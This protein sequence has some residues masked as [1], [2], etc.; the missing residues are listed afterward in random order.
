[1]IGSGRFS[2]LKSKTLFSNL[3][4]RDSLHYFGEVI[5][6]F[7]LKLETMPDFKDFKV[8]NQNPN[9]PLSTSPIK[10]GYCY[11]NGTIETTLLNVSN[12]PSH[13]APFLI[14]GLYFNSEMSDLVGI[15]VSR[16][17]EGNTYIR[18][19]QLEFRQVF[20]IALS[21]QPGGDE[22]CK[23]FYKIIENENIPNIES[24]QEGRKIWTKSNLAVHLK[25][26]IQ[27]LEAIS[28][29]QEVNKPNDILRDTNTSL[30]QKG[31]FMEFLEE[32]DP[33]TGDH[34]DT[35]HG[36]FVL[37]FISVSELNTLCCLHKFIIFSGCEINTGTSA[38]PGADAIQ[39]KKYFTVKVEGSSR[40]TAKVNNGA[41]SIDNEYSQGIIIGAPC[42]PYWGPGII[43][44]QAL[45]KLPRNIIL[46]AQQEYISTISSF[47]DLKS[48]SSNDHA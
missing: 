24:L 20:F 26:R 44:P 1:M 22:I 32:C 30:N 17:K 27:P 12:L 3:F 16:K 19:A 33:I 28:N 14:G 6:S 47:V 41:S 25:G 18:P 38:S 13:A 21:K 40:V 29:S 23:A 45:K 35:E 46:T 43:P 48:G 15:L 7:K 9:L 10:I 42:P 5:L 34:K 39:K 8:K 37:S 2:Y 36:D 4:Y 11:G 31:L